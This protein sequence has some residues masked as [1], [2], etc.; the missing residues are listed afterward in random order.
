MTQ[1]KKYPSTLLY[2]A[3]D[4]SATVPNPDGRTARVIAFGEEFELT[5]AAIEA[6][7]DRNGNTWLDDIE[8]RPKWRIGGLF[9]HEDIAE[10]LNLEALEKA[11]AERL[12]RL[13]EAGRHGRLDRELAKQKALE[14]AVRD[15]QSAVQTSRE[16]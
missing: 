5:E 8:S 16:Y 2:V 7:R 6:T 11:E 13:R 3:K 4:R 14:D 10:Q 12:R 15:A 1:N 9:E